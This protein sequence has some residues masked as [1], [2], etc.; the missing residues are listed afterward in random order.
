MLLDKRDEL[1]RSSI[2]KL[3]IWFAVGL[4]LMMALLLYQLYSTSL[5]LYNQNLDDWLQGET[6][7][8]QSI[9]NSEGI[10]GVQQSIDNSKDNNRYIYQIVH[11]AFPMPTNTSSTS[12]PVIAQIKQ[13][14]ANNDLPNMRATKIELPD[15]SLLTVGIDQNRYLN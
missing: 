6:S 8:L 1:Y 2:L 10:E 12:Y 11:H 5:Q 14:Q 9:A 3:L 4:F 15:G 7:Q 13:Y